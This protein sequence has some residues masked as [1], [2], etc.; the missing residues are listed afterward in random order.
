MDPQ[1]TCARLAEELLVAGDPQTFLQRASELLQEELD[2]QVVVIFEREPVRV[3]ASTTE[4][5]IV[6]EL[7]DGT[8][9]LD[10]QHTSTAHGIEHERLGLIVVPP[11]DAPSMDLSLRALERMAAHL[12][13]H[14]QLRA[15]S[16]RLKLAQE[17]ANLGSY[18]WEIS[19]DT[20]T[21]SDQLYRIYGHD[22][23]AFNASYERFMS[24]VHPDDRDRVRAIHDEAYAGGGPFEMEE[25][26]VRP[27]GDV[28]VLK[29][30]GIV[31]SG[32]DGTPERMTGICWDITDLKEAEQTRRGLAEAETARQRSLEIN[33][34]IVQRLS[35]ASNALEH[36]SLREGI[37]QV[38]DALTEARRIAGEMLEL[39]SAR[40]EHLEVL[41][42]AAADQAGDTPEVHVPVDDPTLVRVVVAD[43]T[44]GMRLLVREFLNPDAGFNVVGEAS[45]GYEAL[46]AAQDLKPDLIVLDLS[47]PELDGMRTIPELQRLVPGAAILVM[48]GY[49][50]PMVERAL[51][52]GA[53]S[54][55]EKGTGFSE[56]VARA[57]EVVKLAS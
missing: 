19:S 40:G 8:V 43:D 45:T 31:L 26:I 30:N 4:D 7:S 44:P 49:G 6:Q 21:W 53:S 29:S 46:A 24:M 16:E 36:G 51:A 22:P 38:H 48:S 17:L 15:S 25:R 27:D 13:E 57:R 35:L 47:M 34:G 33:D 3:V 12:H 9:L 54:Y 39:A 32:E 1:R 18:D 42:R 20:N 5:P 2:A 41:T 55:V 11:R 23:G 28:R 37:R 50:G 52:A 10:G 14:A 56:L